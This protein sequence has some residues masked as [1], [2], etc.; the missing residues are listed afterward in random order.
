MALLVGCSGPGCVS[1]V[2]WAR[3]AMEKWINV[4]IT[5]PGE[6]EGRTE[7]AREPKLHQVFFCTEKCLER[8]RFKGVDSR[9][10]RGR[11]RRAV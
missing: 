10:E 7:E 4:T 6:Y 5:R 2:E 9:R 1:E 8:A 3:W 11:T